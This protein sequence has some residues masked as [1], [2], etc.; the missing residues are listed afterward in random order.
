MNVPAVNLAADQLMARRLAIV[1]R[2]FSFW[3]PVGNAVFG[4]LLLNQEYK[5]KGRPEHERR[6]LVFQEAASQAVNLLVHWTSFLFGSKLAEKL[7][8]RRWPGVG[9]AS[10]EM[11]VTIAANVGSF[12]GMSF[13]RPVVSAKLLNRFM[14][15]KQPAGPSGPVAKAAPAAAPLFEGPPLRRTIGPPGTAPSPLTSPPG[16]PTG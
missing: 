1:S 12:L 11:G 13:L 14:G 7:I 4:P 6:M 9:P 5:Q 8:K 15:E 16:L 3:A 10:L 2:R